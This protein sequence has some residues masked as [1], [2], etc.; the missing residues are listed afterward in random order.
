MN[1][2]VEAFVRTYIDY[3]QENWASLI[4]LAELVINNHDTTSTSISPFFLTHGYHVY[5]VELDDVEVPVQERI[6]PIQRGEAIVQKLRD[7]CE[8]AQASMAVA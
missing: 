4:P 8:W 6:S 3:T 2:N 5:P 7:A 1:Q